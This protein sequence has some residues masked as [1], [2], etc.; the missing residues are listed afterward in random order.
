MLNL[1]QHFN[2]SVV[3]VDFKRTLCLTSLF[4]FCS[5]L[6]IGQVNDDFSQ[7][8]NSAPHV[9]AQGV[10][11]GSGSYSINGSNQLQS[12]FSGGSGTREAWISTPL[13]LDLTT[14][15]HEWALQ[16]LIDFTSTVSDNE[17]RWYFISSA[18][19][20]SGS[21]NGYYIASA[22]G[23]AFRLFRQ[24]GT[25]SS[26]LSLTGGT[27]LTLTAQQMYTLRIERSASGTF[28]VFAN[29][30]SLGTAT[31]NTFTTSSHTGIVSRFT[32]SSRGND[33][34][35]DNYLA[36]L[37]PDVAP[38]QPTAAV[39]TSATEL[40]VTFDEAPAAATIA[41]ASYTL[42]PGG[43][44][45]TSAAAV[46]GEPEAVLLTF[47]SAVAAGN[48]TLSVYDLEDASG[49]KATAV[50]PT[51]FSFTAT[52]PDVSPPALTAI[53]QPE[54]NQLLLTFD[55]PLEQTAAE[56]AANYALN[57]GVTVQQASLENNDQVRLELGQSLVVGQQYE[58]T[59]SNLEDENNNALAAPIVQNFTAADGAGPLPTSVE[60]ISAFEIKV[61]FD[62]AVE[63]TSAAQESNYS[64]NPGI[65][66]PAAAL[67]ESNGSS[68]RLIFATPIEDNELLSLTVS[69][70]FDA[71]GNVRAS[72]EISFTR[73]TQRPRINSDADVSPISANQLR[74]TFS[75]AVEEVSAEILNN[76]SL[77]P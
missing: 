51:S 69:N 47:G 74:V 70:L 62:E 76:Y 33:F 61:N 7:P 64:L 37:Q 52:A 60:V 5:F 72:A 22:N 26:E 54:A 28:E 48:Y 32:A 25:S 75:E 34:Y 4:F 19:D 11:T 42:N 68:V 12:N 46:A 30:T 49:N 27:A 14:G 39:L 6:L 43:L 17:T 10:N 8:L 20:L 63:L 40:K 55:E 44:M 59:I 71:L 67:P 9:W 45:P 56:T 38:P 77:S 65:L 73:D 13:T 31:D 21:L 15:T 3:L 53:A 57:Q 24:T 58:L 2:K 18:E 35:Y 36:Q 29:G 41:T 16:Q 50:A 23:E 66:A 1:K